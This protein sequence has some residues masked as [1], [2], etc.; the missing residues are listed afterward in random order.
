MYES[1]STVAIAFAI[2]RAILLA[3]YMISE[4]ALSSRHSWPSGIL[5]QRDEKLTSAA[6]LSHQAGRSK[7]NQLL[8]IASLLLSIGLTTASASLAGSTQQ[9]AVMKVCQTR[10]ARGSRQI[11]F[12]YSAIVVE[13]AGAWLQVLHSP[14]SHVK[15]GIVAERYG[16]FTLII[17]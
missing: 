4:H 17:L 13:G 10:P 12:L 5:R 14:M 11:T 8:L 16:A 9:V 15:T 2:S 7:R 1:F 3:Q 6:L